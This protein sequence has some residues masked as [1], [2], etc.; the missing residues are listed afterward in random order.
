MSLECERSFIKM[1]AAY[2]KRF[3]AVFLCLHEKGPKWNYKKVSKYIKKDESFVRKWC[4][5][6]KQYKNVDDLPGRGL[7]RKTTDQVDKQVVKLFEK[8]PLMTLRKAKQILLQKDIHMSIFTIRKRLLEKNVKNRS[9]MPKPL[10]S[11]V[12]RE[13]RLHWAHENSDRDWDKVVFTDEA[14]FWLF[15]IVKKAWSNSNK[16]YIVRTVKHP[17]KVHLWGCFN[18]RGFGRLVVF[19]GILTAERMVKIYEKGLLPS[20]DS[21]FGRENRNWVLQEDND[22]KHRSRVC[23]EWKAEKNIDVMEWP[24]SSPDA[25]P[26]ENVWAIMKAKLKGKQLTRIDQLRRCLKRIW[27]DLPQQY[28]INLVG[29]MDNRCQAIISQGGDFTTY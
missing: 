25:N 6:Y 18:S 28:A 23:S 9:T 7:K 11:I 8:N 16:R 1:S 26:I 13:K 19:T 2:H 15:P 5:H 29:S 12:H 3:E 14:S 24:A 22:P 17:G 20:T 27:K 4:N 10:L 21:W